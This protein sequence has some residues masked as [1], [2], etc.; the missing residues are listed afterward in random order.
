MKPSLL[1]L[2]L[3]GCTFA[4]S[5]GC[6]KAESSPALEHKPTTQETEDGFRPSALGITPPLLTKHEQLDD[7]IGQLVA[8]RGTVS[9]RKLPTVIGVDVYASFDLRGDDCYAIGILAKWITTQEQLDKSFEEH[10][11][12]PTRGPGTYYI[13][14]SNLSGTLARARK[15]PDGSEANAK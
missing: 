7:H 11:P 10:G 14:Y 9:K 15:W 13:L 3:S 1:F 2:L 5:T 4:C 12:M 6:Q 8:I